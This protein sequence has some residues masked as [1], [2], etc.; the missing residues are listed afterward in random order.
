MTNYKPKWWHN[1]VVY[2]LVA[3]LVTIGPYVGG[4]FWLSKP[5]D[6]TT[7]MLRVYEYEALRAIFGPLGHLEA[8]WTD[9]P[10]VLMG[11]IEIDFCEPHDS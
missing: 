8:E 6:H 3:L 11:P 2:T 10:V 5:A 7:Y 4:Y 1:W 9:K